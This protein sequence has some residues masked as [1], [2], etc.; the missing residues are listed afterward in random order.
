MRPG[1]RADDGRGGHAEP[2]AASLTAAGESGRGKEPGDA[3]A[4]P[5]GHHIGI[6]SSEIPPPPPPPPAT[7]LRRFRLISPAL[8]PTLR[9][10]AADAGDCFDSKL[11]KPSRNMP[12]TPNPRNV[13]LSR[14]LNLPPIRLPTLRPLNGPTSPVNSENNQPFSDEWTWGVKMSLIFV[15]N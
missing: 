14:P 6:P 9:L 2:G 10:V 5:G 15:V 8:P 12:P 3:V 1:L 11:P 7:F 4:G 13:I